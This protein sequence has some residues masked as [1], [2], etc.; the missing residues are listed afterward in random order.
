MVTYIIR[1]LLLVPVL[2]FGVTVLIF[3]MLQFISP[4]ERTALYVRDIP[5]NDKQIEGLI[6]R[7][8][9]DQ[10]L[11]IQYW[12]WLVGTKD[13]VTGG[14]NGGILFGD[15]GYSRTGSEPVARMIENRFPNTLD[16]TIWAVAP[17]ILGSG[18]SPFEGL[19]LVALGYGV[20]E[21][22]AGEAA[23]HFIVGRK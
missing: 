10:P 17:V 19:D 14:R 9:F 3:G 22:R 4:V 21:M 18:E 5:K 1:R 2:L 8:G 20:K 11:H 12:R 23:C 6:R 7:Y 13:P 16:L 15:F